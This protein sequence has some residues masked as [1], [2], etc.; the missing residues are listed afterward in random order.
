M[1]YPEFNFEYDSIAAKTV[2]D[3]Y[4]CP[5]TIYTYDCCLRSFDV[6]TAILIDEFNNYIQTSKRCNFLERIGIPHRLACVVPRLFFS[7]DLVTVIGFFHGEE[8]KAI[9]QK[10]DNYT[11]QANSGK[12]DG[13]LVKR[14]DNH[15]KINPNVELCV[16]MDSSKTF[17]IFKTYLDKL[18]QLDKNE[19][20][21]FQK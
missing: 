15:E 17:E 16:K 7:C 6:E 13:L 18:K 10:L 8:C 20:K 21:D 14:T 4:S 5:I 1:N 9:F 19:E 2:L 11:I 3:T 12:L